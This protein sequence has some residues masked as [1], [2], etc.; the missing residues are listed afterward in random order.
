M[1]II[2]C[3]MFLI[4]TTVTGNNKYTRNKHTNCYKIDHNL[5]KE[6]FFEVHFT[7]YSQKQV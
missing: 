1:L 3:L 2:I 5:I 4:S 6:S 7:E